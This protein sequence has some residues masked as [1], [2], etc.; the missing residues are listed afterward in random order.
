MSGGRFGY[1]QDRMAGVADDVEDYARGEGERLGPE[2]LARIRQAAATLRRA[3]RMVHCV[4]RL[5][6]GDYGEELFAAAW[7]EQATSVE[8]S[9]R[10]FEQSVGAEPYTKSVQRYPDD[11]STA[12]PGQYVDISVQLAWECWETARTRAEEG[13]A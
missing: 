10:E 5:A 8:D 9:R 7:A 12:W 2:T 4:D 1:L 11:S 6:S 3:A 13:W